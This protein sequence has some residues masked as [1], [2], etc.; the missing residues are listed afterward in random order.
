MKQKRII[1]GVSGS[2]AAY[3]SADIIRKLLDER[4]YVSVIMTKEAEKFITPLTLES[5]SGERVYTDMFGGRDYQEIEHISLAD[6]ADL[7]LIAP[8]TA[9]IIA[10]IAAGICDDLLTATVCAAKARVLFAPA[11]NE[12]MYNN[13]IV[14]DN[15]AKL[16][17]SG[18]KFIPCRRGKLACGK[19][20]EGCLAQSTEIIKAVKSLLSS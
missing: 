10:K 12:N 15:I 1:L 6:M 13:K 4:I 14:R 16:K 19:V 7:I 2:I 3:K 11:M 9:N 8:A 18:F 20:G 5:L 17:N